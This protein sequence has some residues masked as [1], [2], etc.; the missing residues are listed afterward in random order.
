MGGRLR[1]AVPLAAYENTWQV[2]GKLLSV[3]T[4]AAA[5]VLATRACTSQA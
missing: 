5:V 4:E 1:W 3:S 2:P